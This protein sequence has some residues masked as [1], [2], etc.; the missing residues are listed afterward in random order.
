MIPVCWVICIYS[1]MDDLLMGKLYDVHDE[2]S[3]SY[4]VMLETGK[5]QYISKKWFVSDTEK[6]FS[7]MLTLAAFAGELELD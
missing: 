4:L 3:L 5:K 7:K 6:E 1:N 2:N